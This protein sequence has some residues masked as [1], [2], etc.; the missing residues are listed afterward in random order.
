MKAW[1]IVL[2]VATACGGGEKPAPRA[3]EPVRPVV[4]PAAPAFTV[5]PK[6]PEKPAEPAPPPPP[7]PPPAPRQAVLMPGRY[8]AM[9]F[10]DEQAK[11]D[12]AAR[13]ALAAQTDVPVALVSEA[14]IAK[15]EKLV[16][17]GRVREGGPKC[18]KAPTLERAT[19]LAYPDAWG[20][21]AE[22]ACMGSECTLWLYLREPA[23]ILDWREADRWTV[24]G[25]ASVNVQAV[26]DVAVLERELR[27]LKLEKPGDKGVEGGVMGG[28]IGHGFG[29]GSGGPP[30]R[31]LLLDIEAAGPWTAPPA[32][33]DLEGEQK[34]FDACP[35]TKGL[36]EELLIDVDAKGK[37]DRCETE[38]P[39]CL[40]DVI[41][42]HAFAAGPP[43]RRARVR[44]GDSG[45]MGFGHGIG[46][47]IGD[48]KREVLVL[49]RGYGSNF[50][51]DSDVMHEHDKE[52]K[53][54]FAP[55][56]KKERF[57]ANV[58][59]TVDERGTVTE[60]HVGKGKD[61]MNDKEAACVSKWARSLA[62]SCETAG[63]DPAHL[64]TMLSISR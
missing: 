2:V 62:F 34:K 59:M 23:E 53:A 12:A 41:R 50:G 28:L 16:A 20:A 9:L 38:A 52:L 43:L 30:H 4:A 22:T 58:E 5:P 31:H 49:V 46:G 8:D 26:T 37:V 25:E 42:G 47:R 57:D 11:L 63:G 21:R 35:G 33:K 60:A 40:C 6:E 56:D 27:A 51:D 3:P 13:A 19:R 44:F 36:F 15:L 17:A 24:R 48:R 14:D 64:Q 61:R 7:A 1:S 10:H 32:L 45:G 54:C 29:M 55:T 18:A 39:K